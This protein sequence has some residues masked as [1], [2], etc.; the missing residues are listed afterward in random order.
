M[1]GWLPTNASARGR[2]VRAALDMFGASGFDAVNVADLAGAAATTT[3]PLYHHFGSKLGL[4]LVVREDVERRVTDRVEGA[5]AAVADVAAALVVAFDHLERTGL[6]R[7]VGEPAP[8]GVEDPVVALLTQ[9]VG[10]PRGS[11]LAAA[12]RQGLLETADGAAPDEVRHALR[13]LAPS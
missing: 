1:P 13:S 10:A 3:G 4:Y 7:L 6:L 2:L 5:L 9:H 11:M 12:W 8:A